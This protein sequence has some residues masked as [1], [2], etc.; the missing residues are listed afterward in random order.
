MHAPQEL[1]ICSSPKKPSQEQTPMAF[2]SR[3]R[4]SEPG[5]AGGSGLGPGYYETAVSTVR[6]ARPTY[7]PF[8]SLTERDIN[9][10]GPTTF[11]PGPGA[12][13]Q[14]EKAAVKLR[15]SSSMFVSQAERFTLAAGPGLLQAPGPGSYEMPNPWRKKSMNRKLNRGSTTQSTSSLAASLLTG[16]RAQSARPATAG[17]LTW[18]RLPS[19]P[20]IPVQAQSFG[21]TEAYDGSLVRQMPPTM[22]H[23]GH[24]G[25]VP[26]P[27]HYNPNDKGPAQSV[28]VLCVCVCVCVCVIVRECV[29]VCLCVCENVC[30]CERVCVCVCVCVCE[31]VCVSVCVC[32][33]VRV[34]VCA[35]VRACVCACV[36]G[37]MPSADII[38]FG[39]LNV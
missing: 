6:K 22:G 29:Q 10:E 33:C 1:F 25:D 31:C 11:A 9:L 17:G 27:G 13:Y 5:V 12:Y 24:K 30:A 8:S 7:A 23:T 21:Y 35:C 3:S 19:T 14:E 39:C 4:R 37:G 15:A 2:T 28:R 26:A 18:E 16:G 20:S 36:H 38:R 34:C 32:V